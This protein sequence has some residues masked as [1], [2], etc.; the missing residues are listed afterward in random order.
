MVMNCVA[1]QEYAFASASCGTISPAAPVPY[2]SYQ[3][4]N[5]DVEDM[6]AVFL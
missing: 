6:V 2:P 4:P 1:G 3:E 5:P